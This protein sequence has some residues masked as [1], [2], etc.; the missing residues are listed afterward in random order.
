LTVGKGR[1]EKVDV[2]VAVGEGTA[3]LPP[4]E[5]ALIALMAEM[6][7]LGLPVERLGSLGPASGF[8][9]LEDMGIREREERRFTGRDAMLETRLPGAWSN[10]FALVAVLPAAVFEPAVTGLPILIAGTLLAPELAT[11][12]GWDSAFVEPMESGLAPPVDGAAVLGPFS[13]DVGLT[14][15]NIPA[16]VTVETG[17]AGPAGVGPGTAMASPTAVVAGLAVAEVAV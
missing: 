16:P 15:C 7:S 10:E 11:P 9:G 6:G 13:V 8:G 1:F 4:I 3:A 17:L 12:E 2:I 5:S 14:L